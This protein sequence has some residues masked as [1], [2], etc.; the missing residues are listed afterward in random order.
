MGVPV[1]TA[2]LR[3]RCEA[4]R[5]VIEPGDRIVPCAGV[6]GRWDHER[7]GVTEASVA[8]PRWTVVFA[9]GH[10]ELVD[11]PGYKAALEEA[12]RRRAGRV[13]VVRRTAEARE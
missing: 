8:L 12:R 2:Q 9:D 4:C 3:G 1:V 7:C 5:G 10:E 6:Y 13:A 11:T